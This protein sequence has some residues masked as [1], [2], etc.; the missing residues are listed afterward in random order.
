M[1]R[2]ERTR[3]AAT[4]ALLRGAVLLVAGIVALVWPTT[5][6]T[7]IRAFTFSPAMVGL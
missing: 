5:A 6:L 2:V 1:A 4:I 7:A 3:F